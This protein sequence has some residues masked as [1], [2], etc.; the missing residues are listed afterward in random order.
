MEFF[1]VVIIFGLA[2]AGLISYMRKAFK[3]GDACSSCSAD[4]S[5]C[6]GREKQGT[7]H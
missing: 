3:E 6:A 5:Q 1:I 7:C 2:V 4:R